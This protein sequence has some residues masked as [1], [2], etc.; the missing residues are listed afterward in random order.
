[1]KTAGSA[2]KGL[3][4]GTAAGLILFAMLGLLPGSFLG[5]MIGLNIAGALFGF[6]VSGSLVTRLI[7]GASMVMGIVVAGIMFVLGGALI[8]WFAGRALEAAR[9]TRT[10]AEAVRVRNKK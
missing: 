10:S 9:T 8:G 7:V 1:M 4:I 6:P 2:K 5:G 3:Y